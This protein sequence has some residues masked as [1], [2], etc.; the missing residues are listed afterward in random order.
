MYIYIDMSNDE[1]QQGEVIYLIHIE[2]NTLIKIW[3]LIKIQTFIY[4]YILL[5]I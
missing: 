1:K 4:I 5:G 2:Y 3:H